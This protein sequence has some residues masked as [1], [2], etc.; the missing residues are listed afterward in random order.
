MQSGQARSGQAH[1][2]RMYDIREQ[3]AAFSSIQKS[4]VHINGARGSRLRTE[5]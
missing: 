5:I 2:G 4:G 1:S 3:L